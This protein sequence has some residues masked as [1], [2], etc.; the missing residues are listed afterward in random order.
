MLIVL[1]FGGCSEQ[2]SSVTAPS[3]NDAQNTESESELGCIRVVNPDLISEHVF[4]SHTPKVGVL[5]PAMTSSHSKE[6]IEKLIAS[7]AVIESP[8]FGLSPTLSGQ[9]FLPIEGQTHAGALLL[10]DH[11]IATSATLKQIVVLGPAALPALLSHLDDGTPTKLKID[12][13]FGFGVMAFANELR[14]NPVSKREQAVLQS[15]RENEDDTFNREHLNSY[16]VKIG[17]VCLVA[18]GQI[19]AR[20]YQ[21]V[22][23]QPTACIVLN[24]PTHDAELCAQVRAMWKSDNLRQALFD[25]LLLDY[26][27]QGKFNGESLDGWDIGSSLQIEAAIRLLYYFP[28]ESAP[29]I[30]DRIDHL[31]VSRTGPPSAEQA[32][33]S[34]LDS[35]IKRE[36]AN[37]VRTHEF[38]SAI[39]WSKHPA[40]VAAIKRVADRTNDQDI[41]ELVQKMR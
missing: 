9:A 20:R 5:S 33:E 34:E 4:L 8:D 29:L 27:T 12:H 15:A 6:E 25:S 31:D 40:I 21:A 17:D 30:A 1:L 11:K 10:T 39:I 13:G 14:G 19:T 22:R 32:S 28:T 7:L 37:G 23:Y 35:F 2:R 41:V 3:A 36:V 26:S 38:I 18:I 24:S 16:V